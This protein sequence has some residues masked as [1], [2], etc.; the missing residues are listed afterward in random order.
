MV[1]YTAAYYPTA[2]RSSGVGWGMGMGR[3]GA[4]IG[5]LAAGALIAL[6]WSTSAL[7]YA[8]GATTFIGAFATFLMTRVGTPTGSAEI[9]ATE[10]PSARAPA[11]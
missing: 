5:P 7:F 9:R 10:T 6:D 4:I 2:I 1:G 11:A 8:G 3:I